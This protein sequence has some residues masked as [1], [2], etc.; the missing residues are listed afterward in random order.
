MGFPP[1][2]SGCTYAFNQAQQPTLTKDG[3]KRA[4]SMAPPAGHFCPCQG[5]LPGDRH[6]SLTQPLTQSLSCLYD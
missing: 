3:A 1:A 5:V 4:M 2:I 6:V